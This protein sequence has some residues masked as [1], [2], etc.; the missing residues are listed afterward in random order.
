MRRLRAGALPAAILLLTMGA[1]AADKASPPVADTPI[2]NA[3]EEY[4]VRGAVADVKT[5]ESVQGYTDLHLIITT[6][7][8][9]MEV[10]VAPLSYLSKRGFE[11]VKGDQVV[12]T[13]SKVTT[14]DG[15]ILIAR[16]IRKGDRVLAVRSYT[17]RPAWPKKTR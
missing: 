5:H 7:H 16:E 8:G 2:Y 12:V 13:G 10:H 3:A 11:F 9:N 15:D 17:G 1:A 6:E 4:L 14:A